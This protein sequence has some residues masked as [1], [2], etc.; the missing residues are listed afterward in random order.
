MPTMYLPQITAITLS[1]NPVAASGSY[2]VSTTVI[3]EEV[4]IVVNPLFEF[5][6]DIGSNGLPISQLTW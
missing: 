2:T 5:P 6:M 1:P 4:T 3:Q